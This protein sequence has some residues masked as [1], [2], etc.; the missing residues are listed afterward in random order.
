MKLQAAQPAPTTCE[1]MHDYFLLFKAILQLLRAGGLVRFDIH[2]L[3]KVF[4]YI[5]K[6]N[7]NKKKSTLMISFRALGNSF[8]K[9]LFYFTFTSTSVLLL[10]QI[11]FSFYGPWHSSEEVFAVVHQ[12]ISAFSWSFE[13]AFSSPIFF[14]WLQ[15][16]NWNHFCLISISACFLWCFLHLH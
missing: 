14:S 16:Q 12:F 13:W 8:L 3:E 2:S 7:N 5:S 1:S 4:Y 9:Y 6:N 11:A 15:L 10:F